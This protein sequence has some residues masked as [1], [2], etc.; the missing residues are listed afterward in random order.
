MDEAQFE[1]LSGLPTAESCRVIDFEVAQVVA[2]DTSPPQHVLIVAG[3]K[4]TAN[5]RVDLVPLVYIRQPEYWGIEVVGC[6]AGDIDLPARA[7][8]TVCLPLTGSMGTEGVEVIGA[9]RS[10]KIPLAGGGDPTT[11]PADY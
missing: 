11:P 1:A 10:E 9:S 4:P 8:Y 3:T 7:P 6:R 2:L 5:L